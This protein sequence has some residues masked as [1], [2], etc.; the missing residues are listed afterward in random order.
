MRTTR[1]ISECREVWSATWTSCAVTRTR[2][3][4]RRTVPA[5]TWETPSSRPMSAAVFLVSLYFIADV[6]AI[7]VYA[8]DVAIEIA[9]VRSPGFGLHGE[10][11]QQRI[12]CV[13]ADDGHED[14]EAEVLDVVVDTAMRTN[15]PRVFAAG[16]IVTYPGKI[17]LIAVGFGEAAL[18]VNNAAP[19]VDP[20]AGV[21][22]GHSSG[23]SE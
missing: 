15:L 5:T 22:P 12:A 2:R 19:A 17:P 10:L 6:R 3:P 20:S 8:T 9:R 4:A 18:A 7:C 16:D 14:D 21:F 1:I 23:G 13:D 11:R